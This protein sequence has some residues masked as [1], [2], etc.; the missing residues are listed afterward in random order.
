MSTEIALIQSKSLALRVAK[1]L[2]LDKTRSFRTRYHAPAFRDAGSVAGTGDIGDCRPE[3][4]G[5]RTR[6]SASRP[7][8]TP[9]PSPDIAGPEQP[10]AALDADR[11]RPETAHQGRPFGL[12][13]CVIDFNNDAM[14]RP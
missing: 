2:D 4:R 12:V 7:Q 9:T 11:R 14:I 6:A 13:L 3:M 8:N 10:S 5:R 1:E